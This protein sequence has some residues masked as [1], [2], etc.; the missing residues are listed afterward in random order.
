MPNEETATQNPNNPH[1]YFNAC[2]AHEDGS[3]G[4]AHDPEPHLLPRIILAALGKLSHLDVMGGDYTTRD[5]TAVRDYTHIAD[6]AEAHVIALRYLLAE[7]PPM[8]S[9]LES[10]AA[11]RCVR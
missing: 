9:I 5:G 1:V 6:L 2:G 8:F 10:D 11:I 3:H 7:A 4:E